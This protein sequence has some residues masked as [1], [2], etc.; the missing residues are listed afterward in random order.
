M[1][2][3]ALSVINAFVTNVMLILFPTI[4][5]R[6][7][8]VADSSPNKDAEFNNLGLKTERENFRMG[9]L[10]ELLLDQLFSF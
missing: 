3:F 2:I 10:Q 6:I 8:I 5:T 1:Q 9:P 7:L 4:R